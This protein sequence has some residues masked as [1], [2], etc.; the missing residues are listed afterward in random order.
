MLTQK[1]TAGYLIK[2][3]DNSKIIIDGLIVGVLTGFVGVGGGF[4]IVPALVLNG[5]LTYA[6]SGWNEFSHYI[7]K[8]SDWFL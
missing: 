6:F 5:W 8:I 4:L 3:V 2:T 1:Q 7:F